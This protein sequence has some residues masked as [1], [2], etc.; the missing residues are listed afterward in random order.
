M[1]SGS[2]A[3]DL[4]YKSRPLVLMQV[5]AD[6]GNCIISSKLF[7]NEPEICYASYVLSPLYQGLICMVSGPPCVVWC[8]KTFDL[9]FF[10][11]RGRATSTVQSSNNVRGNKANLQRG[12]QGRRITKWSLSLDSR[13]KV[14]QYKY[15]WRRSRYLL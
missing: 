14:Y 5:Q 13:P 8:L 4:P 6:H 9:C 12:A 3:R 15:G 1:T 11:Q 7:D 10:I 2:G